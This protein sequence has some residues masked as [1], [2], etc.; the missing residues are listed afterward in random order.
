MFWQPV[1]LE[2]LRQRLNI[3]FQRRKQVVQ[4]AIAKIRRGILFCRFENTIYE[5]A[6]GEFDFA[7]ITFVACFGFQSVRHFEF[8]LA[9]FLFKK[10]W[11]PA[12][13]GLPLPERVRNDDGLERV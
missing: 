3:V 1:W 10:F 8:H 6:H 13:D 9:E 12:T 2:V 7:R 5:S 11:G 4:Y